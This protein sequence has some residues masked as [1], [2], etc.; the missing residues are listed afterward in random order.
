M[1]VFVY[2]AKQS[3]S[4]DLVLTDQVQIYLEWLEKH[5]SKCHNT[6]VGSWGDWDIHKTIDEKAKAVE[7]WGQLMDDFTCLHEG[8]CEFNQHAIMKL[9]LYHGSGWHLMHCQGFNERGTIE[10]IFV[11]VYD[12]TL[13]VQFKLTFGL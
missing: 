4:M 10:Q 12:D 7:S 2:T 8:K 11:P 3:F 6:R 9:T 5:S 13:A 1:T